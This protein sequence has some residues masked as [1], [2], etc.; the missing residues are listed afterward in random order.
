MI[1]PLIGGMIIDT[2]GPRFALLLTASFCV[3]GQIIYGSGGLT[4]IWWIMLAGR[5]VFGIGG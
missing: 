3:V 2:K 1:V 5:I 4:N